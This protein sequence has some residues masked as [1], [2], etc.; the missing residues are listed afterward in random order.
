MEQWRPICHKDRGSDLSDSGRTP[1]LSMRSP[2]FG[3]HFFVVRRPAVL[4]PLGKRNKLRF[5]SDSL[6]LA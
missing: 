3:A 1:V 5:R 2:A 4:F 6:V